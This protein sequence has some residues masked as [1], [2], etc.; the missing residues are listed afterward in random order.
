MD[1]LFIVNIGK[2]FEDTSEDLNLLFLLVKPG[3]DEF[4]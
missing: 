4:S 2:S 3:I 1:D